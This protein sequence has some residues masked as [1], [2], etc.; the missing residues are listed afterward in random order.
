VTKAS[1][2]EHGICLRFSSRVQEKENIVKHGK[3]E[4]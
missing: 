2:R 4:V 3:T 1:R